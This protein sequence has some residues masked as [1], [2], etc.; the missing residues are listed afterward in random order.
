MQAAA[1]RLVAARARST[2]SATSGEGGLDTHTMTSVS[3]SDAR[4]AMA[5]SAVIA[6]T[7]SVRS[8]PPV[9]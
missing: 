4:R 3:S 9:P 6:P 5:S 1:G 2:H 7:S 8:R